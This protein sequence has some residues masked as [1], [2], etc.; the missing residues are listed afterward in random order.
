MNN[1]RGMLILIVVP[2][3]IAA[4]SGFTVRYDRST[5]TP[6]DSRI[7]S[8][9]N[10]GRLPEVV[11]PA[12][13]IFPY[14]WEEITPYQANL[15]STEQESLLHLTG[16]PQYRIHLKIDESLQI[17]TG[18]QEVLYTNQEEM[19]LDRIIFRIYPSLFGSTVKITNVQVNG[20]Q[21]NTRDEL[22]I[23]SI[24][25][26]SNLEPG[27]AVV[28]SLQ[29][30]YSM[31]R[32]AAS[33]YNIFSS[34][35]GLLTLAH[36]YP[37]LAVY[38]DLGWHTEIPV[39][40]GDVTYTDAG[41]YLVR[42]DA[43]AQV[44]LI[45]SGTQIAQ[46]KNGKMQSVE[47]AAAPARDFFLCAGKDLVQQTRWM[48]DVK[49]NS[50]AP[51]QFKEGNKK[52][53]DSASLAI[54]TISG[55]VRPYPYSEFDVIATLTKAAGVEYPGLTVINQDIYDPEAEFGGLSSEVLLRSV[56]VH[57]VA[58]Q[59]FYNLVGNDQVNEPWLD[60]FLSQYITYRVFANSFGKQGKDDYLASFY[61]RWD[62]VDRDKIPIGLPVSAYS[63]DAYSG[64]IYGRGA[65]FFVQL[66]KQIGTKVIDQFLHDYTGRYKWK[67]AT[68][69]EIQAEMEG[70][71]SCRLDS[72][73]K[74]WIRP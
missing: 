25:L 26:K 58:H 1:L 36:F 50:Y 67:I 54:Q 20:E 5:L 63:D 42:I 8:S 16:S 48:D 62:R 33:N 13:K 9:T 70:A 68:T 27:Y 72:L 49:I 22:S 52:A 28:V 2:I 23:L 18:K 41:L 51:A 38:D 55:M 11:A 44:T 43:P 59:W 65:I 69:N 57:E 56:I 6:E 35:D 71:C 21:V 34:S 4:C 3:L 24:P 61:D 15:R 31:P 10:G 64:I 66:E 37:M 17:I 74:E 12:S 47:Y 53:L 32:D 14:D 46:S 39:T 40:R 7:S 19:A 29:F 60:E 45:A 73:F 30:E